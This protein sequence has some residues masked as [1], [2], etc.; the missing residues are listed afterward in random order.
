[1]NPNKCNYNNMQFQIYI[2]TI[3]YIKIGLAYKSYIPH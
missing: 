1:M 2:L 3:M